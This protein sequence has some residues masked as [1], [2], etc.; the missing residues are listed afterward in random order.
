MNLVSRC[1]ERT[2]LSGSGQIS[3]GQ[4]LSGAADSLSQQPQRN[5]HRHLG[6]VWPR[7]HDHLIGAWPG[8]GR[9]VERRP[10]VRC[11]QQHE[12][13][14]QPVGESSPLPKSLDRNQDHWDKI[15]SRRHRRPHHSEDRQ[16]HPGRRS[17][18]RLQLRFQ[19]RHASSFWIGPGHQGRMGTG[20]LAKWTTGTLRQPERG[21]HS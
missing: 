14:S 20:S 19:Q 18:Q 10:H 4:Q 15:E 21:C 7:D 17:A 8:S 5:L 3:P 11:G 9:P 6:F 2:R 12:R 13:S 16:P 1:G